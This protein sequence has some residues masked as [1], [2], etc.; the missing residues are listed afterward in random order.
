MI[1]AFWQNLRDELDIW[2]ASG[3]IARFWLRDDDAIAPSP[4]LDRL[5]ATL[6]PFKAPV[7]LAIIPKGAGL[8]LAERLAGEALVLPAQHGFSHRNHANAGQKPQE[9]GLHRGAEAVLDDLARGREKLLKL[10]GTS[11]RAVLV[12]PWNRMDADLAPRLPE[13]GFEALSTFGKPGWN[14]DE[15]RRFDSNVDIIDWKQTRTGHEADK[16]VTKQVEALT[17]ARASSHAPVGILTHHLVHGPK[18]WHFLETL[19]EVLASHAAARW[20]SYDDLMN[21]ESAAP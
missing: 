2:Q 18:A 15:P 10:F 6:A 8:A 12:P 20:I 16:Q 14:N 9:L 17:Q 19:G 21:L 5:I 7:L 1:A 11:L 4:A 13:L 3:H